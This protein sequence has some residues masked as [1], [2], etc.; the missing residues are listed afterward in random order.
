M[1]SL[2]EGVCYSLNE[3][4][5]PEAIQRMFCTGKVKELTMAALHLLYYLARIHTESLTGHHHICD[6][7]AGLDPEHL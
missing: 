1:S 6:V 3:R 2:L 5:L 4:S 7:L